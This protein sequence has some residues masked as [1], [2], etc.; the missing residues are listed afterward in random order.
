LPQQTG[1]PE[2]G[3]IFSFYG[4]SEDYKIEIKQGEIHH[5]LIAGKV[6]KRK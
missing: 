6:I 3:D 5:H 1:P 4:G 2:P